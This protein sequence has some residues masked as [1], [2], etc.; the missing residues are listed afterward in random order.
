MNLEVEA[1]RLVSINLA[2]NPGWWL[3]ERTIGM[4]FLNLIFASNN[5]CLEEL[6]LHGNYYS[7]DLTV[8][9]LGRLAGSPGVL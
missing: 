9:I 2:N 8:E 6:L 3:R 1:S 5:S 4:T 7:S